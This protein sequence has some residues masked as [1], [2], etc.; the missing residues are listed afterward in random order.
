MPSRCPPSSTPDCS[1][2]SDMPIVEIHGCPF[3]R[4][5]RWSEPRR[6]IDE[7][8][9]QGREGDS[10][11]VA[12]FPDRRRG[13]EREGERRKIGD[14]PLAQDHN[15]TGDRADSGGSNAVHERDDAGPL[16]CFLKYGAGMIV[17]R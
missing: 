2:A 7:Q 3:E 13:G 10:R 9:N 15:G 6:L 8:P 16:P 5:A 14:R 12:P 17:N 1:R 4:E 11:L